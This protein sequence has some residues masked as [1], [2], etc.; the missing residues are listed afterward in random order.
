[1]NLPGAIGDRRIVSTEDS[2]A[3]AIARSAS[4]PSAFVPVYERH[5]DAIHNF[6]RRRVGL[7]LADELTAEVFVRAFRQRRKYRSQRES[8][9]P[10]LYGISNN[11]VA[12]HRRAERRRLRA[13]ERMAALR[14]ESVSPAEAPELS[15]DLARAL[16]SLAAGDR[17]ALLLLAWGELTYDEVADALR[18]PVG[19]VRS[20]VHRARAEL[21]RTLRWSPKSPRTPGEAHA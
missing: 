1:M 10:W 15:A 4:E 11:L 13:L 6:M 19:T 20:R 7:G 8:A 2:D 9:L 3:D 12:D 14:A 16:R 21:S 18:V 5:F 17:D